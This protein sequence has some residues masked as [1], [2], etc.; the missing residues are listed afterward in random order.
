MLLS[1][2]N[3]TSNS[4]RLS[5]PRRLEPSAN[6]RCWQPHGGWLSHLLQEELFCRV[7]GTQESSGS[8]VAANC[9]WD[10]L[11]IQFP[12]LKRS[13][14]PSGRFYGC[15]SRSLRTPSLK[16]D[17]LSPANPPHECWN[18]HAANTSEVR[19]ASFTPSTLNPMC[20]LHSMTYSCAPRPASRWARDSVYN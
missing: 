4:S 12:S 13:P 19:L 8:G 14:A 18:R 1:W 17:G 10:I 15:G 3:D 2:T 16:A 20:Q 6:G 7:A 9:T 11:D 5:S